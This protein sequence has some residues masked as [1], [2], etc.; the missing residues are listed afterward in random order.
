MLPRFRRLAAVPRLVSLPGR[1]DRQRKGV[2]IYGAI[3]GGRRRLDPVR[4]LARERSVQATAV[5]GILLTLLVIWL[6]RGGLPFDRP[7]AAGLSFAYQLVVQFVLLGETLILIGVIYFVTRRRSVPDMALRAPARSLAVRETLGMV[8]YAAAAQGLGY[9]IGVT[10]GGHPISLHLTGTLYGFSGTVRTWEVYVWVVYNFTAYALIPYAIFRRRGYSNEQLN[11]KS[12]NRRKDAFLIAVVLLLEGAFQLSFNH[13]IFSLSLRQVLIGA[14]SAFLIYF[15]GT[16][17]PIMVFIYA[18]LMPRY[19]RITGSA[20][21]TVILGGLSYAGLHIFESWGVFDSLQDTVLSL[22]FVL[23]QYFGPGMVK[24]ALT[25]R[26]ANAWVHVWAYHAIAPHVTI[27][28]ANVVR[29]LRI[30]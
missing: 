1:A 21:T 14:P 11:L 12:S 24:S 27:D 13:A 23:L 30:S 29:I 9:I 20:A 5:G 25:L 2:C 16:V 26:T 17:V 28:T 8:L 22:A 3:H 15:F 4:A 18:I 10:L 7:A 6:G 19:L